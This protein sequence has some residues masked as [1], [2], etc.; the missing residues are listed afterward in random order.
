VEDE[1][2]EVGI[3]GWKVFGVGWRVLIG[4]YVICEQEEDEVSGLVRR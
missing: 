3:E 1:R 2:I 4:E